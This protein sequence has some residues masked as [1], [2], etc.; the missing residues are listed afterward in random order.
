MAEAVVDQSNL[1]WP[2]RVHAIEADAQPAV[3]PKRPTVAARLTAPL[4][5]TAVIV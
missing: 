3:Q 2:M 1:N 5:V 4:V